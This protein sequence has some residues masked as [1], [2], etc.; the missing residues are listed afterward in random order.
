VAVPVGMIAFLGIL[1]SRPVSCHGLG[2][3]ND[4]LKGS[5]PAMMMFGVILG[6]V[7]VGAMFSIIGKARWAW[8]CVIMSLVALLVTLVV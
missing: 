7:I 5:F 1:F 3:A 6:I 8:S 2:C 4:E